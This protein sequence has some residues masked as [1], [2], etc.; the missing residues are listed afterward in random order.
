MPPF[1]GEQ[2]T[3]AAMQIA[4]DPLVDLRALEKTADVPPAMTEPTEEDKKAEEEAQSTSICDIFN[5]CSGGAASSTTAEAQADGCDGGFPNPLPSHVFKTRKCAECG[6]KI[7][8]FSGYVKEVVAS[9]TPDQALFD[10]DESQS[11]AGCEPPAKK[12]HKVYYQKGCYKIKQFR[13][14]HKKTFPLVLDE[15]MEH[16]AE[17]ARLKA[18]E[19]E[20]L[21]R[22][23]EEEEAERL[24]ALEEEETSSVHS[25]TKSKLKKRAVAPAIVVREAMNFSTAGPIAGAA[26]GA[27]H[28]PF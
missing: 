11:G 25:I 6:S 18:A 14:E 10:E 4:N 17:I 7:S 28:T 2:D 16:F 26:I 24:R 15:L 20:A 23:K 21:R 12:F 9:G 1:A 5:P 3:T 8:K 22:L 27:A 13:D 19:E